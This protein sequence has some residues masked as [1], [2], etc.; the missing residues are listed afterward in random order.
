MGP[1]FHNIMY[2]RAETKQEGVAKHYIIDSHY[3]TV[4]YRMIHALNNYMIVLYMRER[5]SCASVFVG[6]GRRRTR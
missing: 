1:F 4:R 5:E 3:I 2:P 6:D